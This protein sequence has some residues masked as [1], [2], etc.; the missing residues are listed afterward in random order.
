MERAGLLRRLAER[1]RSGPESLAHRRFQAA[2]L[3]AE[4]H[5]ATIRDGILTGA[6]SADER[7]GAG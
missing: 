3:E 7:E 5:A 4:R 1:V 2:A 6:R